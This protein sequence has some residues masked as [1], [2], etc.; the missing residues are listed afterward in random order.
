MVD[1]IEEDIKLSR[2]KK[3]L[4]QYQNMVEVNQD[5]DQDAISESVGD[6]QGKKIKDITSKNPNSDIRHVFV[7][8]M[9]QNLR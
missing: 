6:M 2:R 8:M 5:L 1:P 4:E 7:N 9:K 3:R